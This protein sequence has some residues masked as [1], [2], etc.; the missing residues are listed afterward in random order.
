LAFIYNGEEK[1]DLIAYLPLYG[2]AEGNHEKCGVKGC[3]L[4]ELGELSVVLIALGT[5]SLLN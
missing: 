1:E 2:E 3:Q 4:N 5:G